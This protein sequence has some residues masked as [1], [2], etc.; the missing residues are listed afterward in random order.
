MK[1]T[2][3]QGDLFSDKTNSLAHCVSQDFKMGK[4]IAVKFK[5]EF[6]GLQE[7]IDQNAEVGDVAILER[8]KRFVLYMVTKV[9]YYDKPDYKTM[10]KCIQSLRDISC[11]RKI[12]TLSIPRIGCGLD[13]LE[14]MSVRKIL[15]EEFKNVQIQI[16]VYHL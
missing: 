8:D 5:S 1:V 9:R 11:Q 12:E 14:W 4:G 2:E 3:I 10:R 6:G 13:R 16:N 15:E 7:L